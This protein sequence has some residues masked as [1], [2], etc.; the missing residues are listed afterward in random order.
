[1]A[2]APLVLLRVAGLPLCALDDLA[3]STLA[4]VMAQALALE[5]EWL[6]IAGALAPL[7][8]RAVADDRVAPVRGRLLQ[9]RRD[10]HN[11]R[12]P[13]LD[14][15]AA[16]QGRVETALWDK[17]LA[18]VEV[19]ALLQ[20]RLRALDA[21]AE[22][23]AC[24][25]R[26]VL[27]SLAAAPQ[28]QAATAVTNAALRRVLDSCIARGEAP[29]PNKAARQAE[30]TLLRVVGRAAT[31]TTPLSWLAFCAFGRLTDLK[32]GWNK[33]VQDDL[34]GRVRLNRCVEIVLTRAIQALPGVRERLP[35]LPESTLRATPAGLTWLRATSTVR[36]ADWF[37]LQPRLTAVRVP[38][39]PALEMLAQRLSSEPV[40]TVGQLA[41]AG[42][43][44]DRLINLGM[45]RGEFDID[46]LRDDYLPAVRD[47]LAALQ[48]DDPRVHAAQSGL[49][50]LESARRTLEASPAS[51]RWTAIEAIDAGLEAL[52]D[53]L[54][55]AERPARRSRVFENVVATPEVDLPAAALDLPKADL[56]LVLRLTA[57]FDLS[58]FV[59]FTAVAFFRQHFGDAAS[60]PLLE[61]HEELARWL[62]IEVS[63]AKATPEAPLTLWRSFGFCPPGDA[64]MA[65]LV[66]VQARL[67]ALLQAHVDDGDEEVDL[68]R[69]DVHALVAEVGDLLPL[70]ASLS[71]YLRASRGRGSTAPDLVLDQVLAGATKGFSRYLP[72][73]PAARDVLSKWLESRSQWQACEFAE[74]GSTFGNNGSVRLPITARRITFPGMPS[75]RRPQDHRLADL[76]VSY[77]AKDQTLRMHSVCTGD[78]VLPVDLG[79]VH[80][81]AMPALHQFL[82]QVGG[83][84][85]QPFNAAWLD[86]LKP[87]VAGAT[88]NLPRLRAGRIVL[89]GRRWIV[90]AEGFPARQAATTT[91]TLILAVERWRRS[92]GLPLRATFHAG[93]G[94]SQLKA[95]HARK[96]GGEHDTGLPREGT[97]AAASGEAAPEMKFPL[98]VDFTSPLL[99]EYL[100]RA[101]AHG[102]GML[103]FEELPTPFEELCLQVDGRPHLTEFLVDVDV[104]P[105]T[106]C[107]Q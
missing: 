19:Q 73:H 32:P 45:A 9:V 4:Q 96:Q 63:R 44:A 15:I 68:Q 23:T 79:Q 31:R 33:L 17:L 85:A 39:Q 51:Q 83:V 81:A 28:L 1:M 27:A 50:T 62:P 7:V 82:V 58:A 11:R 30:I 5:D 80:L 13:A 106:K 20:D 91:G 88:G 34:A 49:Y 18:L 103:T 14:R 65:R 69:P 78:E 107:W 46:E 92:H 93:T 104:G 42:E 64:S 47:S 67:V 53:Q 8:E 66:A 60:V 52:W 57:L 10:L 90:S 105:E 40:I 59:R 86:A 26:R 61:V 37:M 77:S 74:V 41:E 35:L 102:R 101:T 12:R 48:L 87:R 43:A 84:A 56:E 75:A 76:V 95:L 71:L 100:A 94:E 2:I 36:G 54:N 3:E 6:S 21:L 89:S 72:G 70:R 25:G 55:I 16:L 29:P 98:P 38:A 22:A 24:S 97:D 99:L